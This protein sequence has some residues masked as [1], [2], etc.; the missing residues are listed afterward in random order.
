MIV[1]SFDH[2][3]LYHILNFY[4][5]AMKILMFMGHI[6]RDITELSTRKTMLILKMNLR[7]INFVSQ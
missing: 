5:H 1:L 2:P 3:F 4:L 6:N 7:S